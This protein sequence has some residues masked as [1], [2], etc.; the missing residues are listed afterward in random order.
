[1]YYFFVK[2]SS[3]KSGRVIEFVSGY[4]WESSGHSNLHLS[5]IR[6]ILIGKLDPYK[7]NT[8]MT[9]PLLLRCSKYE[10]AGS[11]ACLTMN[12]RH[13]NGRCPISRTSFC[14][15]CSS[16]SC[17]RSTLHSRMAD[18]S[19]IMPRLISILLHVN[20]DLWRGECK[21]MQFQC[22]FISILKQFA[23]YICFLELP[24]PIHASYVLHCQ[25]TRENYWSDVAARSTEDSG[26]AAAKCR[27]T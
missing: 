18:R 16:T 17:Q 23:R 1:M 10:S 11:E 13:L 5:C 20:M 3:I 24:C 27:C 2:F 9:H 25:V 14:I 21:Y 19:K 6:R 26:I 8:S 22:G 15:C 4:T 12:G 7:F